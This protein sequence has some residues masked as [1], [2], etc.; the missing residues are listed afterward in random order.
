MTK[1]I[2]KF[3]DLFSGIGGIRLGLELSL[4]KHGYK[5]ECVFVSEI[6]PHAISILKQN[7]PKETITG[8]ITKV[9]S[10]DIPDFDILCGG[11]PCQA[12][13]SAGN[14]NGFADTRGT[15]FFDVER[16]I[17]DKCPKGFILENVEGLVNHD[18]GNTLEVIITNLSSLGYHVTYKV[19]NSLDFGV[20]QERK[21]V[22]FVGVRK[23]L[24]ENPISLDS[25]PVKRVKL[26]KILETGQ[27][28]SNTEF[29]KLL[30]QKFS[31]EELYG[32]SIK[33][34]RGGESNIHSWDLEIKGPVTSEEKRFLN[35]LL[36]ER[37]KKKWSEQIG[38]VWM[39]GVPLTK[40][41]IEEFYQSDDLQSML[42]NLT[43]LGYI[44][45]EHP[46]K[47]IE[48]IHVAPNGKKVRTTKRVSDTT[49]PKGYNI[50][51]GKLSFEINKILDPN[52]VAPTLVAT[53]MGKIYVVDNG[54]LRTLTLREGLR[55]FGYPESFKFNISTPDGF[56]LLGNTVVV[57]VIKSIADRLVEKL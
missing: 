27:P 7:H 47:Q 52:G 4:K 11:F 26:K 25:F 46:K 14:R 39:D 48:E 45:Y 24:S 50:V 42:D 32:K 21:R 20:P 30:L 12:F 37:R 28:T 41:Q 3:I 31:V 9:M 55:M 13:S 51:T 57:P 23:D 18:G 36:K 49:K 2:I 54:G 1:P 34:K 16:I 6:K 29:V 17:K 43:S 35:L 56:D 10:N 22:Y 44:K 5:P 15:L 53:D 40:E 33:D 8:D 38:I 19:L